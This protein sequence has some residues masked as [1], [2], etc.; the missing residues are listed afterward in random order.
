MNATDHPWQSARDEFDRDVLPTLQRIGHDI[1]A[2]AQS[3][4]AKACEIVK[5]YAMLH[6]SFDP[7]TFLRLKTALEDYEQKRLPAS[8]YD[9]R[10]VTDLPG[11][12]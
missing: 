11:A 2:K 8:G 9:C 7:L 1:G 3:G 12:R 4:N 6:R 10:G 5:L